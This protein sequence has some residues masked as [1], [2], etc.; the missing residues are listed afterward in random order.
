MREALGAVARAGDLLRRERHGARGRDVQCEEKR[1]DG[2]AR[3]A[4]GRAHPQERAISPAVGELGL[5]S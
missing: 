4:V 2:E 3:G 1:R 5:P